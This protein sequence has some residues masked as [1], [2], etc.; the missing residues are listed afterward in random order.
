MVPVLTAEL[1]LFLNW[2]LFCC[3][4]FHFRTETSGDETISDQS[5]GKIHPRPLWRKRRDKLMR[6]SPSLFPIAS[7]ACTQEVS[8]AAACLVLPV[9]NQGNCFWFHVQVGSPVLLLSSEDSHKANWLIDSFLSHQPKISLE[10]THSWC[11]GHLT[12]AALFLL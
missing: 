10:M 12:A 7:Q 3:S 4:A 11:Q 9:S 1:F 2:A 8:V 6:C 5:V